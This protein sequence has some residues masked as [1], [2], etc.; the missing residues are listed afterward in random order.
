MERTTSRQLKITLCGLA[1]IGLMAAAQ[2]CSSSSPASGSG[3]SNGSAGHGTGGTTGA[4]IGG[5]TGAGVGGSSVD[6]GPTLCTGTAPTSTSIADFTVDGGA[7]GVGTTGS[8]S[9]AAT[10]LTQPTRDTSSG[11]M[12][13]TVATGPAPSASANYAGFGIPFN[14]CVDATAYTGVKFNIGGTLSAG[15]TI[16]F[17][18]LFTEDAAPGTGSP[19]GRDACVAASCYPPAKIFT[20]PP[21]AADVTVNFA[22]VT[23]G[24]PVTTVD[25][26]RMTG[27]QWQ[28]NVPSGDAGSGCTGTLTIDNVVF[29]P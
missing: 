13:V 29:V 5:T 27:V 9:Y 11:A 7:T 21:S 8:Y 3:G 17:S 15:C 26:A 16:Q 25:K 4:G 1:A 23:G 28:L 18:A 10:G 20:L 2:G 22:D 6:A 12:V 14:A 24:A 19:A